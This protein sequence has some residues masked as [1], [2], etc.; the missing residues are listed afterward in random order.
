[1]SQVKDAYAES[2]LITLETELNALTA[3]ESRLLDTFL[4]GQITKEIY[5]AKA[6][7]IVSNYGIIDA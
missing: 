1:M 3:K 4:D 2:A 6:L 5:N 7:E